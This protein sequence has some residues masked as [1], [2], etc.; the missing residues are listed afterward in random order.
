[1]K[2]KILNRFYSTSCV[3]SIIELTNIR[4]WNNKLVVDY[5][6]RWR[7]LSLECKDQL[8]EAL[9]VE[10]CSQEMDWDIL[11]ALQVNKPK[12]FQELAT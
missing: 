5:I 9:A 10:M 11:Y 3:I 2:S 4:Q 6:N 12:T 1:M 8:S 7:A